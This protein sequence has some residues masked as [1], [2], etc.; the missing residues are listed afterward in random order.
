[1]PKRTFDPAITNSMKSAAADSFADNI[2]MIDIEK[3][4]PHKENFYSMTDIELLAD[5]IERQGLKNN[6]VVRDCGDGYYTVISGHRRRKALIML[7]NDGRV[8]SRF[9][10]CYINP[11]KTADEEMQ[12]L[13]ML[14]A[15]SRVISDSE[16]IKQYELLK[17][18]L[19]TKK[20]NGE[21]VRIREKIAEILGISNGKVAMIEAVVNDSEAKK[22]VE[23]G[24]AS[25][26]KAN[27]QLKKEKPNPLSTLTTE[28]EPPES[29]STLTTKKSPPASLPTLATEKTPADAPETL[30]DEEIVKKELARSI[31]R[32][33]IKSRIEK[34]L[35]TKTTNTALAAFLRK[36]YGYTSGSGEPPINLFTYDYKGIH[37]KVEDKDAPDG[38]R[39]LEVTW[40]CAAKYITEIFKGGEKPLPTLATE[41]EP[42]ASLSTLTTEKTPPESLSTLTTESFPMFSGDIVEAFENLDLYSDYAV[43]DEEKFEILEMLIKE[44]KKLI[45]EK[46]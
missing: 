10:P 8:K 29:L 40:S 4:V 41:K 1:M 5:D 20:A 25:I 18:I 22:A 2:K 13:I 28:K 16:M 46:R 15:T 27:A 43:T 30:T 44:I 39:R 34:F 9:V 19:E 36:E 23:N 11:A 24:D 21:N 37:L 45:R 6:L 38:E 32:E 17:R 42:P 14:N 3:L 33:G 7:I 12:D 31:S 35:K 26:F